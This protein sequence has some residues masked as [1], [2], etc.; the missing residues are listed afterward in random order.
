MGLPLWV[1]RPEELGEEFRADIESGMLIGLEPGDVW[2]EG[3]EFALQ[4]CALVTGI[5]TRS[6]VGS[7]IEAG[8]Y[9][10][11]SPNALKELLVG[12]EKRKLVPIQFD[13]Q[14]DPSKLNQK[15]EFLSDLQ[16]YIVPEKLDREGS[17]EIDRAAAMVFQRYKSLPGRNASERAQELK[18]QLIELTKLRISREGVLV[19]KDYLNGQEIECHLFLPPEIEK[20]ASLKFASANPLDA[21]RRYSEA[22]AASLQAAFGRTWRWP[23]LSELSAI[24][25]PGGVCSAG[26][27]N[28]FGFE[29]PLAEPYWAQENGHRC[30]VVVP[31]GRVE[32]EAAAKVIL[33]YEG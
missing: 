5:L 2:S 14:L 23:S 7:S 16:W 1:D 4:Q 30:L 21:G 27:A 18:R 24:V 12:F 9:R 22:E 19:C 28:P 6:S 26:A 8:G 3:L 17:P 20:G 25:D 33:V 10:S 11:G 32:G 29:A 15:A 13:D 31:Q